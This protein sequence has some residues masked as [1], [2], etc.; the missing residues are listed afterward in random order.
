MVFNVPTSTFSSYNPLKCLLGYLTEVKSYLLSIFMIQD[1][2]EQCPDAWFRYKV[3]TLWNQSVQAVARF[4]GASPENLVFV[5]NATSGINTVLRCLDIG[6]GNHIL[7]TNQTYGA[8]QMTVQDMC[9]DMK[10]KLLVL[11]L[12]FPTSDLTG[13]VQFYVQDVVQ[14]YSQVLD[15]NPT[16]KLAVID[17]I[18]SIS[19][20][21]LPVQE[22]IEVCHSRGVLVVIDGA[23]AP[24]Q[25]KLHLEK[26]G[27]D[28][29]VGR[30]LLRFILHRSGGNRC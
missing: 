2:I 24:G 23:H 11:N 20:V 22:L 27:A 25:V 6:E 13:S 29:F 28:F 18:T 8:I 7:I 12:T 19:A 10:A 14:Q 16:V 17:Y 30:F 1:T 9:Q 15:E 3:R 26:L 21:Q 5:T 4:V